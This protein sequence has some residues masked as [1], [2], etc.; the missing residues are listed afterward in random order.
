MRFPATRSATAGGRVPV[1]RTFACAARGRISSARRYGGTV[2]FRILAALLALLLLSGGC[3]PD[4]VS[5]AAPPAAQGDTLPADVEKLVGPAYASPQ[6]QAL[7]SRVGQ[8]LV[9]RSA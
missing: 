9:S 5:T 2:Y 4:A 3:T 1:S 7:V 8:R 6:L